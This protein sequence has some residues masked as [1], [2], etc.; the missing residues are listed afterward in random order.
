MFNP[1]IRF[2]QSPFKTNVSLA[3]MRQAI[4]LILMGL[5]GL[6][7]TGCAKDQGAIDYPNITF[8][9]LPPID[10]NVGRVEV[11]QVAK[12][13]MQSPHVEGM[14][15]ISLANS[16]ASWSNRIKAKGGAGTLQFFVEEAE[17]TEE[18]LAVDTSI[19]AMVTDEQRAR[20]NLR[21]VV[22]M[23]AENPNNQTTASSRSVIS[24]MATLKESASLNDRNK[25]L[26]DLIQQALNDMNLSLEGDVNRYFGQFR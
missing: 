21:L 14:A 20:F 1:L 3:F 8:A 5:V 15:P 25:L 23:Q 10:L 4:G 13:N 22:R 7:I 24:R 16:A 18:L 19:K 17:I 11:A 6:G 9:H 26:Y 2:S 12:P